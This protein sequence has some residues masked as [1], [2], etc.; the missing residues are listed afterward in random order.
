MQQENSTTLLNIGHNGI[1]GFTL[2]GRPHKTWKNCPLTNRGTSATH[3]N[4][5]HDS[6]IFCSCDILPACQ[7]LEL[8]SGE[9]PEICTGAHGFRQPTN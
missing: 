5:K 2:V 1:Y 9:T 4:I 7:S 8:L 6:K 3:H